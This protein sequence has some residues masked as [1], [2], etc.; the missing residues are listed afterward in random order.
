MPICGG[1]KSGP[2]EPPKRPSRGALSVRE[3]REGQ[4][5]TPVRMRLITELW[6]R[7]ASYNIL[8]LLPRISIPLEAAHRPKIRYV[9]AY[10]T[11][12]AA[13]EAQFPQTRP[14][15]IIRSAAET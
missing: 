8:F 3:T 7:A 15:L 1:S 4:V 12:K 11:K 9:A 14:K 5:R 2:N 10:Q 6:F 13:N